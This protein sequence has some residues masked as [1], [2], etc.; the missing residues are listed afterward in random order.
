[1]ESATVSVLTG[2]V[3]YAVN[4]FFAGVLGIA[5]CIAYSPFYL[6]NFAFS[7][8]FL[9]A[10][11]ARPAPSLALPTTLSTTPFTCCSFMCQL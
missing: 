8:E 10:G 1:V 4:G 3:L 11:D 5:G 7:F 2:C 9:V 6:V